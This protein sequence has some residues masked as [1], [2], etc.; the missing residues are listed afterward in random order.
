MDEKQPQNNEEAPNKSFSF[1]LGIFI[2]LGI[3]I[4]FVFLFPR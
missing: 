1:I 3:I 2:A 4:L